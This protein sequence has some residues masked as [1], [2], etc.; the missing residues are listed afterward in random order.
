MNRETF[1]AWM[2]ETYKRK[3][4][5][6]ISDAEADAEY[7]LLTL[8]EEEDEWLSDYGYREGDKNFDS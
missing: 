6:A 8:E 5:L 7:E 1:K 3:G 4:L 2:E